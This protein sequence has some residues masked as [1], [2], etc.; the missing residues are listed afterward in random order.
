MMIVHRIFR[1]FSRTKPR[2]ETFLQGRAGNFLSVAVT[3]LSVCLG[4]VIFRS[5]DFKTA[6][7]VFHGLFN[8]QRGLVAVHTGDELNVVFAFAVIAI[9]HVAVETGM[10][11]KIAV[12]L[13]AAAWGISYALLLAVTC[14]VMPV[15]QKAFIYFQF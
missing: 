12:R 2:I 4:W 6:G 5:P 1:D 13:P 7:E 14:K 3:Y 11:H 8:M 10:W 15:V 9:C